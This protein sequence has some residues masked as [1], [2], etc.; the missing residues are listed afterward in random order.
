MVT[1]RTTID[2]IKPNLEIYGSH[3]DC[4][5]DELRNGGKPKGGIDFVKGRIRAFLSRCPPTEPERITAQLMADVSVVM[6]SDHLSALSIRESLLHMGRFLKFITGTDPYNEIDLDS[7]ADWFE[8][9]MGEFLFDD[10][11]DLFLEHLRGT[12]LSE[13][14]SIRRKR[15]HITVCSRILNKEKGVTSI[16]QIDGD[17][18]IHLEGL[19]EGLCDVVSKKIRFDLDEFVRFFT[20]RCPLKDS[21][22]RR[23][24]RHKYED[25]EEWKEFMDLVD[26]YR[27]DQVERGLRPK[28]IQGIILSVKEGYQ[29]LVEEFGPVFPKDINY[30]H[31]RYLRN[32]MKNL[33]QRTIRVYLGRLGKML[34]FKFGI[35]PYHQADLV[36]SPESVERSWIF[37]EQWK[38]LWESA[39]VTER[40]V[41]ALTGGMGLRRVEV[42]RINLAD[43]NGSILTVY[44]KG[45]GPKGKV[46]DKEIPPTVMRCIE[47][48]LVLRKSIIDRFG[49]HSEGTLLV[50]D[51]VK[52]GGPASTR[53][54]ETILQRLVEKTK[55]HVTCHTLRRFYC[56][57][58]VDAGTEIDT[59]RRMMRH[60]SA[61][62]TYENYIYADPRK[63]ATATATVEGAIFG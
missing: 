63:L 38:T 53:L 54:V 24:D 37:K 23:F 13:Y 10:E 51:S 32:N 19:M 48:Y 56:M 2:Y 6:E 27:N 4:Y 16:D 18:F 43:I 62:T 9:H 45:H 28:S 17:C 5:L 55:I 61:V 1:A 34:E 29:A 52:K 60:E 57:A 12:G 8:G 59:V 50:M 7:R 14:N 21:K 41:L 25:T 26:E 33:K 22:R 31:I 46:V 40:L 20:D 30:H 11:L 42:A 58:L 47:D 36:W 15:M 49:D 39:D 3:L 35:N 44:G